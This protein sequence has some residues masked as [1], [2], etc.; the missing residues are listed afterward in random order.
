[1]SWK[2]VRKYEAAEYNK[3]PVWSLRR[4]MTKFSGC[5]DE[6]LAGR[7]V[8]ISILVS[9]LEDP[10]DIYSQSTSFEFMMQM[11]ADGI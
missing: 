3:G 2:Y 7:R 1:M 11:S 6:M 5:A 8:Q 10:Y 9:P 4:L